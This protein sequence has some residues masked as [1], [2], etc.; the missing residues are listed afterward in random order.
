ME[1]R[2]RNVKLFFLIEERKQERNQLLT[3]VLIK[4]ILRGTWNLVRWLPLSWPSTLEQL[5]ASQ[6]STEWGEVN[7][8]GRQ[9]PMCRP[10]LIFVS[11]QTGLFSCTYTMEQWKRK[12]GWHFHCVKENIPLR[13]ESNATMWKR[14]RTVRKQN[15]LC[16]PSSGVWRSLKVA[17]NI[18]EIL[19][20]WF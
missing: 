1:P 6:F 7:G 2:P 12:S 4:A 13:E 14:L 19:M 20:R 16:K 15:L 3:P 10:T 17:L 18:Y 9:H 5:T 8:G 11:P